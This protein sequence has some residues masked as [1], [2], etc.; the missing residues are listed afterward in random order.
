MENVK[1]NIRANLIVLRKNKKLTQRQLA[2]HLNYSDKAVSRWELGESLPDIDILMILCDFYGVEFEWL[3]KKHNDE[4]VITKAK[5]FNSSIRIIIAM[6]IAVACYTIATLIFVYCKITS[7][8]N[9]WIVFIWALTISSIL[10]LLCSLKWWP[11][12]ISMIFASLSLWSL[13]TSVFLQTLSYV[14]IW[15]VYLVGIPLQL[16]LVLIFVLNEKKSKR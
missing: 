9:F 4:P 15:S 8:Y 16:I 3:I 5:S 11:H 2:E 12:M 10:V 14:N 1:E 13:L 7:N 6:L